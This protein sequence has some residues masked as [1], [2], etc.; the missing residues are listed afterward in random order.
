MGPL[1][2][3]NGGDTMPLA[4]SGTRCNG[5][6]VAAEDLDGTRH[7]TGSSQEKAEGTIEP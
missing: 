4:S 6:V 3:R 7:G 1:T 2:K 5:G